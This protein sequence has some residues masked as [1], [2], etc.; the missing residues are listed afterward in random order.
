MIMIKLAK[1]R[2]AWLGYEVPDG[3]NELLEFCKNKAENSV[4]NF[5]NLPDSA[6]IPG[7]LS[8]ILTDRICGEYLLSKRNSLSGLDVSDNS[9]A[10]KQIVEGDV[11]VTYAEGTSPAER[12]DKLVERLL[13]CGERE[14]VRFR[15][16]RWTK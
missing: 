4:R 8:E 16:I 13:N 6:E 3:D 7:G 1:A 14:L 12:L 11:S 5:C 2:L 9:A 10:V 15:K